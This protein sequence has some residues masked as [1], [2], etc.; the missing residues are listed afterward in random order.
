LGLC[1]PCP[2][3]INNLKD[4]SKK[5]E[6]YK[7]YLGNIKKVKR[8]LSGG[9]TGIKND[10]LKKMS[11]YSKNEKYELAKFYREK[12]EIIEKLTE[13]KFRIEEYLKNPNLTSELRAVELKLLK[14]ELK[15]YKNLK[16]LERIECFDV[17]HISGNFTTA[18]MVTFINGAAENNYYKHF[19]IKQTKKSS[20]YD[21]I[22]EVAKRRYKN[23]KTWGRPDLILVDG[24]KSQSKAFFEVFENNVPIV[25]YAKLSSKLVIP[26]RINKKLAY[27][28]IS[29]NKKAYSNL[30]IRLSDEAHRFARRY[31]HMLLKKHYFS[32][33]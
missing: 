2:N 19:R 33:K 23:I 13:K 7:K 3:Y 28:E 27:T 11:F 15:N 18:S 9:L 14:K 26:G 22:K 24:G 30:I 12:I 25:G 21:S 20:D 1:T 5:S 17:A 4:S 31:H 32:K 16:K 8:I 29:I 6:L 10:Y